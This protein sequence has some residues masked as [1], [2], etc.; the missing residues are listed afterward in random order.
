MKFLIPCLASGNKE[1]SINGLFSNRR[2][3]LLV[4][5]VSGSN[6]VAFPPTGM[7]TLNLSKA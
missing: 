5:A 2:Q 1:K 7:M 4:S 3:A 6:R